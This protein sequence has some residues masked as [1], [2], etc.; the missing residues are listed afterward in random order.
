MAQFPSITPGLGA[1]LQGGESLRQSIQG[2][3]NLAA[4]MGAR[5]DLQNI[6][7][8][9]VEQQQ[10]KLKQDQANARMGQMIDIFKAKQAVDP[11]DALDFYTR[12]I[13]PELGDQFSSKSF[14]GQEPKVAKQ[15]AKAMDLLNKTGRGNIQAKKT[16]GVQMA[17]ILKPLIK[18]DR[19]L[20]KQASIGKLSEQFQT[21]KEI[22][23]VQSQLAPSIAGPPGSAPTPAQRQI[24]SIS[25]SREGIGGQIVG[26]DGEIPK[27][28][29]AIERETL[30]VRRQELTERSRQFTRS[31]ELKERELTRLESKLAQE[32]KDKPL[33]RQT[34]TEYANNIKSAFSE[35]DFKGKPTGR[36]TE[37]S[38]EAAWARASQI[39]LTLSDE[40][41]QLFANEIKSLLGTPP[42]SI[43]QAFPEAFAISLFPR[44]QVTNKSEARRSAKRASEAD[45]EFTAKKHGITTQKVRER[46]RTGGQ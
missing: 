1:A 46:L 10:K 3:G 16:F 13:A 40:S 21:A 17:T 14:V 38:K 28:G 39:A 36:F 20:V 4:S 18:T 15:M 12:T 35:P 33:S 26:L 19:E 2:L 42:H 9:K 23:Q 8:Q 43:L 32:G 22:P 45:I 6:N 37:E 27:G 25:P 29:T 41:K 44:R 11:E 5:Q 34:I 7:Q 31:S 24:T 30:N